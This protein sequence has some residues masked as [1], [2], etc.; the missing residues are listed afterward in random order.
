MGGGPV[1]GGPVPVKGDQFRADEQDMESQVLAAATRRVIRTRMFFSSAGIGL[2]LA[3]LVP[4][5]M[6]WAA[7]FDLGQGGP[8]GFVTGALSQSPA[9]TIGIPACTGGAPSTVPLTWTD[10]QSATLDA[11]GSYL[12]SGYT[13]SRSSTPT[14]ARSTLGTLSGS[15]PGTSFTDASPT[16]APLPVPLIVDTAAKTY[17]VPE[18]TLTAGAAVTV[19]TVGNQPNDYQVTPDGLTAV[20]A[21]SA[22]GQVQVLSFAG[23]AW[24]VVKTIALTLPIAVAIDPVTNPSGEYVAYVVSDT[25]A[26][27]NGNVYPITLNGASTTLGAAI[28]VGH[29]GNPTAISALGNGTYVYVANFGSNTV[30]AINAWT[31]TATSI[32]LT[33]TTP[34]PISIA[35]TNDS[36]HV[37]VADGKN[38]AIDDITVA[39]NT[40]TS[41]IALTAGSL[42]DGTGQLTSGDPG[43]MALTPDCTELYVAEY[44]SNQVQV[45]NTA[46][47]PSSPDTVKTSIAM[48]A[49]TNPTNLTISPD[50]SHVYVSAWTDN[51]MHVI[52]TSTNTQAIA[53]TL[54]CNTMDPQPMQVT[55]DGK[56]LYIP[57]SA[58]GTGDVQIM[59]TAT[60]AAVYTNATVG[61][62]KAIAMPPQSYWYEVTATHSNWSSNTNPVG[63]I[64][65]FNPGGVQ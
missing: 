1:I 14:G 33:G 37:Y 61:A 26:A 16:G 23:G 7:S 8:E 29:Q 52:T 48:G 3:L 4:A 27:S 12:V 32:A 34:Q 59:S 21:E 13:V 49:A 60:N 44:A 18:S 9:V 17:P 51:D 11:A 38:S 45:V 22:S 53:F 57:E 42:V 2:T 35:S 62:C 28:A 10:S 65:G 30:S 63:V 25:G 54:A 20:L 41:T 39:S 47:A 24:S 31:A 36:T 5:T 6:A 56:E 64:I 15:P 46:L 19:G 50:G 40:T 43:V 55:P 58:C